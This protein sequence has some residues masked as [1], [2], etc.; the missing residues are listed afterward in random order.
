[1]WFFEGTWWGVIHF[2]LWLLG[3][4]VMTSNILP[5]FFDTDSTAATVIVIIWFFGSHP[6]WKILI[7][8][9]RGY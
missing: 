4:V 6:L 9:I 8:K 1:M 7:E 3:L 2:F 5:F